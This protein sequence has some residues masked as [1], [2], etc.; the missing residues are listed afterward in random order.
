MWC[1]GANETRIFGIF[2]LY[3]FIWN[4]LEVLK[5]YS[6]AFRF[7]F[8]R[9]HNIKFH[10][11]FLFSINYLI[12]GVYHFPFLFIACI[13][14]RPPSILSH[15]FLFKFE[16]SWVT[17]LWNFIF[18]LFCWLCK[19]KGIFFYKFINLELFVLIVRVDLYKKII[20]CLFCEG[21]KLRGFY[22]FK[23]IGIRY[24]IS[25]FWWLS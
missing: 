13:K 3:D 1:T 16:T 11:F 12:I 19:T 7:V 21:K 10:F 8:S 4:L 6:W 23:W 2:F 15:I 25:P 9:F 22:C 5:K 17:Y 24:R 14:Y 20:F 18:P